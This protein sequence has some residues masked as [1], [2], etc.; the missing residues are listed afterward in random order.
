MTTFK[1]NLD[2]VTYIT[3]TPKPCEIVVGLALGARLRTNNQ[4]FVS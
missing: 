1:K 3:K 2:F 4:D